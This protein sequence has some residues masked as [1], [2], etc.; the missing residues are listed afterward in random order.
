MK[1]LYEKAGNLANYIRDIMYMQRYWLDVY[2][3]I[4]KVSNGYRTLIPTSHYDSIRGYSFETS[5]PEIDII[6]QSLC[7]KSDYRVDYIMTLT[8]SHTH[9]KN[10]IGNNL[11]YV[12]V[13]HPH[14]HPNS[15]ERILGGEVLNLFQALRNG[16][17]TN[18]IRETEFQQTMLHH[19]YELTGL[20]L[21]LLLIDDLNKIQYVDQYVD[22]DVI[23]CLG[24]TDIK[25]FVPARKAIIDQLDKKVKHD[26]RQA[27][28]QRYGHTIG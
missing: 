7:R 10:N 18:T 15:L 12:Y 8:S 24:S 26:W 23:L 21:F 5:N 9:V 14:N 4:A 20:Y 13:Q 6:F 17:S 2:Q 11:K 22:K 27:I 16:I 19:D 3:E 28:Q 1:T 25:S